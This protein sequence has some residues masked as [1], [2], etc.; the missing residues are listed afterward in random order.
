M[1]FKSF[2]GF[3]DVLIKEYEKKLNRYP[4]RGGKA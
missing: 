3:R 4:G 2:Q 1:V